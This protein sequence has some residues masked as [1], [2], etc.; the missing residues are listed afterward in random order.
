M[1]TPVEKAL[2]RREEAKVIL[3]RLLGVDPSISMI[4][5]ENFVDA[6]VEAVLF[7]DKRPARLPSG[8]PCT[9]HQFFV[10]AAGEPMALVE[11][12]SGDVS[13][14]PASWVKFEDRG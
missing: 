4:K 12:E 10:N 8:S 13:T 9:W 5:A 3:N 11:A 7:T 14:V 6:V 1:E 2:R